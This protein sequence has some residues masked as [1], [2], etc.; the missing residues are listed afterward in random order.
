MAVHPERSRHPIRVLHALACLSLAA[1]FGWY[2]WRH[3]PIRG[4]QAASP[5]RA[6]LH[7][8]QTPGGPR[9]TR[10]LGR[11]LALAQILL[12]DLIGGTVVWL[13]FSLGTGVYARRLEVWL[14]AHQAGEAASIRGVGLD[15]A[16]LG[17]NKDRKKG[18][19]L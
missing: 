13:L 9:F 2:A 11:R 19:V 14:E 8:L 7:D 6:A 16:T 1:G 15:Q 10:E 4:I 5:R 12:P 3:H 18:A 17:A